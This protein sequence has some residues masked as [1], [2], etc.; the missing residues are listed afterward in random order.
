MY[1]YFGA[2]EKRMARLRTAALRVTT[3]W[4]QARVTEI[5]E[6]TLERVIEPIVYS[7]ALELIHSHRAQ[8]RKVFI[9]SASPEE[10]VAPLAR[11]LGVDEAIAT[12]AALDEAGRYTGE[13]EFYAYGPGK[14]DAMEHVA[15]RDG[16]DLSASWAYSDSAT[17]EP[18]LRA[19]GHPV[20]VNPD[21]DLARTARDEDWEI[22]TFDRPVRLP[23]SATTP[24]PA[25]VGIAAG[26]VALVGAAVAGGALLRRRAVAPPPSNV[27]R[28][29]ASLPQQLRWR[30]GR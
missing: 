30:S 9:V 7:E 8:G 13:V 1:L 4:E 5:V 11:F 23:P 6:E 14:A 2:D 26:A 25:K 24:T 3:G 27:R 10:I 20:A 19:V 15:R 16:I 22:R 17:D 21:R 18:M 28:F 29:A 12:R